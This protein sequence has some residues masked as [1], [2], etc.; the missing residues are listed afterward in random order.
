MQRN[1]RVAFKYLGSAVEELIDHFEAAS[2]AW[3]RRACDLRLTFI[4]DSSMKVYE[5]IMQHKK[6][7][8]AVSYMP[9]SSHGIKTS[10]AAGSFVFQ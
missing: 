7:T 3:S 6:E 10:N 1:I 2:K 5:Y 4:K 8:W 9:V